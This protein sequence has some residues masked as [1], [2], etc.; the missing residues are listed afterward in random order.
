M[1]IVDGVTSQPVELAGLRVTLNFLIEIFHFS[2]AEHARGEQC[3]DLLGSDAPIGK[4]RPRACPRAC[5]GVG[6]P[7]G[8]RPKRGAGPGCTTPSSSMK[9]PRATLCG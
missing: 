2:F 6:R 9:E 1:E 7:A 8:V 5:G 4:R 3:V